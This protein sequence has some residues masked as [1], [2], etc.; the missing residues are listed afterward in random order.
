MDP[1]PDLTLT[2]ALPMFGVIPSSQLRHPNES[3]PLL[4]LLVP[5]EAGED[6][7]VSSLFFFA[8]PPK[9]SCC[10][11]CVYAYTRAGTWWNIFVYKVHKCVVKFVVDNGQR[12]QELHLETMMSMHVELRTSWIQ[13]RKLQTLKAVLGTKTG[14]N[15]LVIA[16]KKKKTVGYRRNCPKIRTNLI[17]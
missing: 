4:L 9:I 7:R 17:S 2:R 5:A 3:V 14:R 13:H 15:Q 16:Y 6:A 8:L 1:G 12:K 10:S 11:S